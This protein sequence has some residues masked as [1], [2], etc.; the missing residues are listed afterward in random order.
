MTWT[1]RSFL[2]TILAGAT[3]AVVMPPLTLASESAGEFVLDTTPRSYVPFDP[4][5]QFWVYDIIASVE[6]PVDDQP[7][8]LTFTRD[9]VRLLEFWL[10]QRSTFRWVA[11]P[12]SELAGQDLVN[13]STADLTIVM[14][15]EQNGHHYCFQNNEYVP[16]EYMPAAYSPEDENI[17]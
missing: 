12:G 14:M 15:V 9:R 10:H 16:L 1:R 11:V 13:Q 2:K 17:T 4:E 8:H 3:A 6:N 5:Q 7:V